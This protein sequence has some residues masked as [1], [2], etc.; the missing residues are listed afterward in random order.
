MPPEKPE[1]QPCVEKQTVVQVDNSPRNN[2]SHEEQE[3]KVQPE[4]TIPAGDVEEQHCQ[5]TVSEQDPDDD[6]VSSTNECGKDTDVEYNSSQQAPDSNA[7]DAS[8]TVRRSAKEDFDYSSYDNDDEPRQRHNPKTTSER[9]LAQQQQQQQNSANEFPGRIQGGYQRGG[10]GGRGGGPPPF[11]GGRGGFNRGVG[12][13]YGNNNNLAPNQF[14]PGDPNFNSMNNNNGGPPL[15]PPG[16]GGGPMPMMNNR[17]PGPG[18]PPQMMHRPPLGG[19]MRPDFH[20]HMQQGN[21]GRPPF[22]NDGPRGPMMRPP[23]DHMGNAQQLPPQ[24]HF[25]GGGAPMFRPHPRM[26]DHGPRGRPPFP[27]GPNGPP[28]PYGPNNF[29]AMNGPQSFGGPM[30]QMGPYPQQMPPQRPI[31]SGRPPGPNMMS[32][33]PMMGGPGMASNNTGAIAPIIPRKV[34]INPNFKGG[35]VEAATSELLFWIRR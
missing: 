22:A 8:P 1:A 10:R 26:P 3:V 15:G 18:G 33:G 9:E 7:S 13:G 20:P 19:G 27:Q 30:Q 32:S 14:Y 28:N 24:P 21:F 11:R 4:T 5:S 25:G 12:M 2:I 29:N 23:F 35:G 31:M 34:L 6:R 16:G 17:M